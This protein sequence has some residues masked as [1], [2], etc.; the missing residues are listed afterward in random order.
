MFKVLREQF[1]RG[2]F[3]QLF[4]KPFAL[5][6]HIGHRHWKL[7][8]YKCKMEFSCAALCGTVSSDAN[9]QGVFDLNRWVHPKALLDGNYCQANTERSSYVKCLQQQQGFFC[10][11]Q[12]WSWTMLDWAF[13]PV[14]NDR[15]I[16][17]I[18]AGE[19]YD[20]A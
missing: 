7:A 8:G 13:V 1:R 11:F 5:K 15:F 6:G 12:D 16:D 9:S 17:V 4:L 3:C 14:S 2:F 10:L 19:I 20:L 18:W